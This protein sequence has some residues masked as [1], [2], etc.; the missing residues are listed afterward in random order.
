MIGARIVKNL[1]KKLGLLKRVTAENIET[2]V[3]I[4]TAA[5]E[6]ELQDGHVEDYR[7]GYLYA[8]IRSKYHV[9]S[10]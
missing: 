3:A 9:I 7:R 5:L 2:A 4:T 10:R 8:Y 1:R 6:Q